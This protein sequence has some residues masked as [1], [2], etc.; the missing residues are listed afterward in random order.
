MFPSHDLG[1]GI[2][3]NY[4]TTNNYRNQ[5]LNYWNSNAD[6]RMDFNIARS[7]GQTPQTIMSVG[8]NSNVGIGTTSPNAK[9][10]VL[11][12]ASNYGILSENLSG[13]G[14]FQLKST[15]VSQT[16]SIGAVDNSTNSDLFIYGGSSAG[17]KVTIQ[18]TPIV[19]GKHHILINFLIKYH[20]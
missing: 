13:Y 5:I 11:G 10:H 20:N 7:S 15:T 1:D 9:L 16:W 17:T 4:D 3:F 12:N 8:Y 19:T 18:H 2:Q 6:S 14:A